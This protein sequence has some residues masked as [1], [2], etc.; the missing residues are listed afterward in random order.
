MQACTVE[1]LSGPSNGAIVR[2]E[3]PTFSIGSHG[4]NDLVLSDDAISKHHL[5]LHVTP[6]GYRVVDLS[7][8]NGT[9]LGNLKITDI[10]TLEPVTLSLGTTTLRIEP[11]VG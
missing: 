3:K 5:E 7:S 9:F 11:A 2:V 1:V 8:S 6:D 4:T 10:T